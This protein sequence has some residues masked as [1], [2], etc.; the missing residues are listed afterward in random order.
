[1]KCTEPELIIKS[2]VHFLDTLSD[3]IQ[4]IS[5]RL[6]KGLIVGG[7]AQPK[8]SQRYL[9]DRFQGLVSFDGFGCELF[10]IVAFGSKGKA[11]SGVLIGWLNLCKRKLTYWLGTL[12]SLKAFW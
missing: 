5:G 8:L 12:K 9:V 3:W 2:F 4:Q 11:L 6:L 10:G 1:M 7:F